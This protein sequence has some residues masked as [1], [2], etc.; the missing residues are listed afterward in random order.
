MGEDK[1]TEKEPIIVKAQLPRYYK[2][3]G[4]STKQRNDIYKIRGKYAA[5][6]EKLT[7]QIN[8]LKEQ[9][10]TDLENVLT[11]AQK[12]RLKE[13]ISGG[14]EKSKETKEKPAEDKSKPAEIKKIK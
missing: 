14:A 11:A 5:E 3:L 7:Q 2:Q 9:E 8:A 4:L 12:A 6:I 10:K 13:I 1:K